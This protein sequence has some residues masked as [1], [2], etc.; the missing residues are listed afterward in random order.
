MTGRR[1]QIAIVLALLFV[2]TAAT[3]GAVPSGTTRTVSLSQLDA[4]VTQLE[5]QV[6]LLE[7]RINVDTIA[8]PYANA[9]WVQPRN[10]EKLGIGMTKQQVQD[11]LGPPMINGGDRWDWTI[12]GYG[13]ANVVF[14]GDI[15]STWQAPP[16]YSDKFVRKIRGY[17]D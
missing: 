15:V 13:G 9:K 1:V 3:L 7:T 5:K 12:Q 14:S 16:F 10:W 8:A 11:L 6:R 2:P 17:G 4:R